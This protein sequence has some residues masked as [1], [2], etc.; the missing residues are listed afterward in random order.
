M[1]VKVGLCKTIFTMENQI[2]IWYDLNVYI[3]M[4]N[5]I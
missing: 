1:P 4:S 2:S 5:H 3:Y